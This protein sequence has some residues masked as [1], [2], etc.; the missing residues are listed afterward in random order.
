MRFSLTLLVLRR[1]ACVTTF[2]A[3]SESDQSHLKQRQFLVTQYDFLHPAVSL[4]PSK[5]TSIQLFRTYPKP[6]SVIYEKLQAIASRIRENKYMAAFRIAVQMIAYQAVEAIEA[7]SHVC[8]AGCNIYPR[9][10]SK[11]KHRLRPVQYG[12]QTFQCSRIK[13]TTYFYPT[14]AS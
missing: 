14:S 13:S 3:A 5:F 4:R 12:Q 8:R 6:A 1:E 7:F 9:R 11:P 10:R 2:G